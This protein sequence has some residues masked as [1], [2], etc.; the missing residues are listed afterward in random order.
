[1]AA[2]PPETP[3]ARERSLSHRKGSYCF[4]LRVT[5]VS[6]RGFGAAQLQNPLLESFDVGEFVRGAREANALVS[7]LLLSNGWDG[8]ACVLCVMIHVST[9]G[10]GGV[11]NG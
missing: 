8:S 2:A 6:S 5:V 4:E 10:R 7:E 9:T 3:I 1:M 11:R